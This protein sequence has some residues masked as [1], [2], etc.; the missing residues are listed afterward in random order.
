MAKKYVIIVFLLLVLVISMFCTI[1]PVTATSTDLYDVFAVKEY[2]QFSS[3]NPDY[4]FSKPNSVVAEAM[5]TDEGF[6][7]AYFY[8]PFDKDLLNGKK[9]AIQWRWYLDYDNYPATL[10]ELY[11][12]C[13]ENNRKLENQY[14]FRCQ[15]DQQHPVT[16]FTYITACSYS[17]TSNGGWIDWR[18][19]T[20]GILDLSSFNSPI[21][22]VMIKT[23][24]PWVE[25][26]TGLQFDCLQ[27]LDS[28]NE[29]VKEVIPVG[30]SV[31]MEK[32]G[33]N[34]DYGLIRRSTMTSWGT[35]D[36]PP[37]SGDDAERDLSE[38]VSYYVQGLFSATNAYYSCED[39]WGDYTEPS[40]VYWDAYDDER[41]CDY[42]LVLYKGHFWQS[43]VYGDDECGICELYHWGVVDDA[44][45][46]QSYPYDP[47]KDYTLHDY[48]DYGKIDGGYKTRGTHDFVFIWSCVAGAQANA[49]FCSN[50][51]GYGTLASWMDIDNPS[52]ELEDYGYAGGADNSDHV[53]ISF[54]HVSPCYLYRG[55]IS[56]RYYSQ[57][58]YTFFDTA[59]QHNTVTDSL[60]AA[61]RFINGNNVPFGSSRLYNNQQVW[62]T[63]NHCWTT[64][65]MRVWGDGNH[66]IPS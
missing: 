31:F 60:D 63:Y 16:D 12:V 2:K 13:H 44:G 42:S 27:I 66:I 15:N 28:D 43:A 57:F 20:S 8:I 3:Y 17:A 14:E 49:G 30:E 64:T 26:T 62:D 46:N 21:V 52:T 11:V 34:Y 40:N 61:S 1:S 6:G 33:G 24:D 56:D 7:C 41:D 48:I 19:D 29:V 55:D 35:R 39:N 47:I 37:E 23:I 45:Y 51:H 5:S 65:Q 59:L 32:T 53:F 54:S 22:E 10:A 36:Y 18:V 50:G 25:D 9:L 4:T 58:V 38:S